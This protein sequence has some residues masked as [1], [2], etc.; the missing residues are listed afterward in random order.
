MMA[1][2]LVKRQSPPPA[3]TTFSAR[4]KRPN[5]R[6]NCKIP[7]PQIDVTQIRKHSGRNQPWLRLFFLTLTTLKTEP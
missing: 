3:L 6:F 5:S 7:N 4:N 2:A 1:E